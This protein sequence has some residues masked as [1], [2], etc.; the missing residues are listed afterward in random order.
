MSYKSIK[1]EN[2]Y[3]YLNEVPQFKHDVPDNVYID[4]TLTGIG[5]TTA[6]LQNPVDYV[7]AIPF[8]SLGDN[9]KLQAD[10]DPSYPYEVFVYHSGIEQVNNELLSYL[11][12]NK[13]TT[14]KIMVTYDSVPKLKS[15]ISLKDYKLFIDEGHKLLEYAG[16][17][18]PKVIND[19]LE[20]K[21]EF[22]AY[23]VATATPTKEEFIPVQL[24]ETPKL[25][26]EWS[27]TTQV[28]FN[29][30]R[31]NQNQVRFALLA[32]CL[33]HLR[34]DVPGN[35]YVFI[36]SVSTISS[37]CKDLVNKYKFSSKDIKVICADTPANTKMLAQIGKGFKP[38]AVIEPDE[39]KFY[40]VTFVTSTAFEGQDFL[41]PVGVTY[42]LSDGRLEHT[43]LDISTQVSQ[44]V[45]RLRVSKYKDEIN[46]FWTKSQTEGITDPDEYLAMVEDEAKEYGAAIEDFEKASS[47][48]TKRALLEV[49]KHTPYLIEDEEACEIIM[50]PNAIKHLMNNFIGT[51]LQYYVSG[52]AR[53]TEEKVTFTLNEVFS[54]QIKNSFKVPELSPADKKKLGK[55]SNFGRTIKQYVDTLIDFRNGIFLDPVVKERAREF[56]NTVKEDPDYDV[57]FRYCDVFGMDYF[58]ENEAVSIRSTV[59]EKRL[60]D[61][62][63]R[64]HAFFLMQANYKAGTVLVRSELKEL[65]VNLYKDHGVKLTA[66]T[67]DI[68]TA[69]HTKNTTKCIDGKTVHCLKLIKKKHTFRL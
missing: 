48:V 28:K 19:L 32:L 30:C 4:K 67:T 20:L 17:F 52:C 68:E 62:Y 18:K 63:A 59:L 65:L 37:I 45:G 31:L 44:I 11:E 7:I 23:V 60:D 5:F 53:A 9:K 35:A 12:R 22:K 33:D 39:D 15:F 14:K 61:Y 58:I 6:I 25:K 57:F 43:K 64:E 40:R 27:E 55:K 50:N 54:G 29:H 41:D 56:L 2:Q 51:T 3:K 21:D 46:M 24:E 36:N 47:R 49:A 13:N 8:K 16:N 34:D 38:K 10:R 69:F 66:K 26:L 1:I 42:I